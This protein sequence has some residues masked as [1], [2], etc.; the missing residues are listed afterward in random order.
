MLLKLNFEVLYRRVLFVMSIVYNFGDR[1]R[2]ITRQL[3]V[4][5]YSGKVT[6]FTL[7]TITVNSFRPG[8][9]EKRDPGQLTQ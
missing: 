2:G 4:I 9:I 1:N 6:S 7:I 3:L 5:I 8:K